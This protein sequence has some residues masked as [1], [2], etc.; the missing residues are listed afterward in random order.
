MLN[1]NMKK[2]LVFVN[3]RRLQCVRG[4][5]LLETAAGGGS[6]S[7]SNNKKSSNC[8]PS[9]KS[10]MK[11]NQK[12]FTHFVVTSVI[13][14]RNSSYIMELNQK[15]YN[16]QSSSSSSLAL[17]CPSRGGGNNKLGGT[18]D[19]SSSRDS[20]MGLDLSCSS[21][22]SR[23]SVA[24]AVVD[25]VLELLVMIAAVLRGQVLAA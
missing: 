23:V 13:I 4:G 1:L 12:F 24:A 20:K 8:S 7:S 3:R 21:Q 9:W 11:K 2:S 5:E 19:L 10:Y 14:L 16:Y 17:S 22:Y 15:G 6:I 25:V 18:L